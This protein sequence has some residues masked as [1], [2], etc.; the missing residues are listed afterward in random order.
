[1]SQLP[2][3]C[4]RMRL[5]RLVCKAN[6]YP[7]AHLV[8]ALPAICTSEGALH[9]RLAVC[10]LLAVWWE[11]D[12][13]RAHCAVNHGLRRGCWV[14][15]VPAGASHGGCGGCIL[16]SCSGSAG[17][18]CTS[19]CHARTPPQTPCAPRVFWPAARSRLLAPVHRSARELGHGL[20]SVARPPHSKPDKESGRKARL[21]GFLCCA[22]AS[23]SKGASQ[24]VHSLG[25]SL[26]LPATRTVLTRA[27]V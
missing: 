6:C 12:P 8:P 18:T 2:C 26:L 22:L 10:L 9:W 3:L 5:Y 25:G 11:A 14:C 23:R 13:A 16:A 21:A 7:A 4:Q 20:A 17:L 27:P 1:M 24:L 15:F 19:R